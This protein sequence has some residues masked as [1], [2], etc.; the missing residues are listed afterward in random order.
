MRN[1]SRQLEAALADELLQRI[2]AST[3]QAKRYAEGNTRER[4]LAVVFAVA[5]EHVEGIELHPLVVPA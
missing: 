3:P 4:Q 1:A 2:R 5:C